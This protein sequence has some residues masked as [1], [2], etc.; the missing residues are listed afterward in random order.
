MSLGEISKVTRLDSGTIRRILITLMDEGWVKQNSGGGDYSLSLSVLELGQ[1][2]PDR[3]SLR[4][5]LESRLIKLASEMEATVYLSVLSKGKALC[6]ARFH[7]MSGIEVRWWSVGETMPLNCGAGPRILLANMP[8]ASRKR[9]LTG[10]LTALTEK[11]QTDNEALSAE[12]GIIR[13]DGWALTKDDV[14]VGLSALAVPLKNRTGEVIAAISAGGLTP[15]ITGK[16]QPVMLSTMN[17]AVQEMEFLVAE[18]PG[19]ISTDEINV[20]S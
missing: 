16:K 17:K 10:K 14:A 12:L 8:D 2:V 6:L 19:N 3:V 15:Q 4:D 5:L 7:G 9:F 11:S 13:K 20:T 1:A 18:L